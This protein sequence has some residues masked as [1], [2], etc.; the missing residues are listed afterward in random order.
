MYLEVS[1]TS[2]Q[3]KE[4]SWRGRVAKKF[5]RSL[6]T[7]GTAAT[8]DTVD[9]SNVTFGVPLENCPSSGISTVR[10]EL[11]NIII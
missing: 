7:S 9:N 8:I 11:I 6:S 3:S 10:Y 5:R 4:R 2:P 1:E